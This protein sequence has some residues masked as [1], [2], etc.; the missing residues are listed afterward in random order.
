MAKLIN[1]AFAVKL[2]KQNGDRYWYDA[3]IRAL[4]TNKLLP[5]DITKNTFGAAINPDRAEAFEQMYRAHAIWCY[6][7]KA[8]PEQHH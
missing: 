1:K 2:T 3:D 6:T 4:E 8:A 7:G 5:Y